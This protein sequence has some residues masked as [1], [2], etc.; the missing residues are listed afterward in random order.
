MEQIVN[1]VENRVRSL[2]ENEVSTNLIGEYVMEDLVDLDEI[3][4]F[5]LQVFIASSKICLFS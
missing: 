4:I 2:G 1:H 5:V 3:A